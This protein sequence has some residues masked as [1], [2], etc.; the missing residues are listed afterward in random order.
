[1]GASRAKAALVRTGA[2]PPV[3][4]GGVVVPVGGVVVPAGVEV[5]AGGVVVPAG[6]LVVG[7]VVA[8]VGGGVVVVGVG[9]VPFTTWHAGVR[10]MVLSLYIPCGMTLPVF[11]GRWQIMQL[12]SGLVT[13]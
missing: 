12:S 11:S 8:V 7:L 4:A 1:V 9:V 10:H 3:V 13:I 6:V 5:L 2:P